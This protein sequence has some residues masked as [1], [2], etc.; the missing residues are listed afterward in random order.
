MEYVRHTQKQLITRLRNLVKSR[1]GTTNPIHAKNK[2]TETTVNSMENYNGLAIC[3]NR[4]DLYRMKKAI[5]AILFHC[6]EMNDESS[7]HRFCPQSRDTGCKWQY[8]K[9]K[10]T[11]TY[12]SHISIPKWIH[13]ILKPIFMDLPSDTLLRKCLHDKTQNI[14]E[15]LNC[16]VWTRCP[17][18]S[19]V[20]KSVF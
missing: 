6:T 13:N 17:K 10:G 2:L 20:S 16:I 11:N 15:C 14:N 5:G 12:K 9:L 19:F 7:R 4:N 1:K 3:N 18:N 8:D